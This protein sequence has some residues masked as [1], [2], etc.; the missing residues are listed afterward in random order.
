MLRVLSAVLSWSVPRGFRSDNPCEF[1]PKFTAGD[2]WAAWSWEAISFFQEHAVP[3]MW[4]ACALALFTGQRQADV[5]S[6]NW[7]SIDAGVIEVVQQKTQTKVWM[8][9]H[10]DLRAVLDQCPRRSIKTLCTQDGTP[11][12]TD[13]FKSQWADRWIACPC[14]AANFTG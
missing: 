10:R 8:P 12:T 3:E 11:W 5:L 7:N 13:G 4:T 2:G 14:L 9:I 6:M 1:V